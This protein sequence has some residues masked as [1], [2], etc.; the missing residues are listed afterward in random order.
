MKIHG[1]YYEAGS[2]ASHVATLE[3]NEEGGIRI[4]IGNDLIAPDFLSITDRLKGVP[5]KVKFKDGSV[6]KQSLTT[7]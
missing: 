4:V 6:L 3:G 7:Q 5:R 2:S 1:R